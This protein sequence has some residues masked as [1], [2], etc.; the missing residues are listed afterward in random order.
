[1]SIMRLSPLT[2]PLDRLYRL[3]KKNANDEVLQR[4]QLERICMG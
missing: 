4:S 1:M 3:L 2:H